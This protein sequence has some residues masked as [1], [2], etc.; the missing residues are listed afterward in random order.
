MDR[1]LS[2]EPL[3]EFE[4]GRL[5]LIHVVAHRFALWLDFQYS[6]PAK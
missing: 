1:Q 6:P 4:G 2:P 3:K 5:E